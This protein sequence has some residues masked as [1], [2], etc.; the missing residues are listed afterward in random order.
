[1]IAEASR[2]RMNL[3]SPS[4]PERTPEEGVP[5]AQRVSLR[6]WFLAT[7]GQVTIWEFSESCGFLPMHMIAR[8]HSPLPSLRHSVLL[9][10]LNAE[11]TR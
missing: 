1:M 11:F 10:C 2:G 5:P 6:K 7:W 8:I 9:C 4:C 3:A